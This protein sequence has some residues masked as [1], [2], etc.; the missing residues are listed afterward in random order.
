MGAT[1]TMGIVQKILGHPLVYDHLR[2]FAVGGLD[3]TDF[4]QRAELAAEDVVLDLGCGTGHALE[5]LQGF[6]TYLGID[7]DPVA[8]SAAQRRYA[9]RPNV[10]FECKLCDAADIARL[11]PSVVVMGGLLHHLDDLQA[12]DVLRLVSASPRLR[13]VL[14]LDIVYLNGS[15]HL[16]SN[17]FAFLDRGRHC[18]RADAYRALAERAGLEF[19][20]DALMWSHP[21]SRRA[22]YL[23]MTLAP[24]RGG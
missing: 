18:R 14:T 17:L 13:R 8:I 4:Y 23:I 20:E 21:K 5:Y 22:R 3:Y 12:L 7:T 11:S 9:G 19:V 2:P 6:T 16:L 15:E 1:L 24:R 10:S